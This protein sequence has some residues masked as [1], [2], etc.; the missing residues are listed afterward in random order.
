MLQKDH[1]LEWR[2]I[3]QNVI[4]GLEIRNEKTPEK[5]AYIE[6]M[7]TMPYEAVWDYFCEKNGV[8]IGLKWLDE[9]KQYERD[10]L[11]KRQ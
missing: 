9:V 1:L 3:Y 7:K 5:L 11:S 8:P 6:E 2:T 10:I 4:L